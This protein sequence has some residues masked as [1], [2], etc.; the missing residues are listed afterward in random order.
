MSVLEPP[1]PRRR[2]LA[3][4]LALAAGI[5]PLA[6]ASPARAD[7]DGDS[8]NA[9][10]ESGSARGDNHDGGSSRGGDS[11]GGSGGDGDDDRDTDGDLD[12][13]QDAVGRGEI[14]SLGPVREAVGR[15]FGGEIIGID[16]ERRKGRWFYEFKIVDA[17]GRLL[18]VEVDA[19]TARVVKVRNR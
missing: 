17:G 12:D 7:G 1:M 6:A 3:L 10:A 5:A 18:E 14:R 11:E 19:R 8:G 15:E 16:I 4:F 2:L 9:G 13:V